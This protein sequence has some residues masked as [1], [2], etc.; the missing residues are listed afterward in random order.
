MKIM[1]ISVGKIKEAYL[2]Q[3]IKTYESHLSKKCDLRLVEIQDEKAPENLSRALVEQ[4]KLKEGKR[5]LSF[6]TPTMYV[7]TLEIL[8]KELDTRA[9]SQLIAQQKNLEKK[10]YCFIIGGSVGLSPEVSKR[11]NFKL[12]F[13]KMTVPHQVMKLILMEQLCQII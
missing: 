7:V 3:G 2:Q 9:F 8:G 5:I 13:S 6:I 11:S 10:E 4:I 1:V 12:S